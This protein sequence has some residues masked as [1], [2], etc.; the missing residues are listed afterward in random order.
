VHARRLLQRFRDPLAARLVV[1]PYD[2]D[3]R[4]KQG[5]APA[6][7]ALRAR[8]TQL[9]QPALPVMPA[10]EQTCKSQQF[11]GV[12]LRQACRCRSRRG[13]PRT[14]NARIVAGV[15][16]RARRAYCLSD[17]IYVEVSVTQALD[18][19]FACPSRAGAWHVNPIS[20]CP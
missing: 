5:M 12:V 6:H 15:E 2:P 8:L 11:L 16:R 3:I 1:F 17:E 10:R 7:G 4:S 19:P 14:Q 20:Q 13:Q 18:V 9:P